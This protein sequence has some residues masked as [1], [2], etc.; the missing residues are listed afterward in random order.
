MKTKIVIAVLL[1]WLGLS[2]LT[3][4]GIKKEN[5]EASDLASYLD[6]YAASFSVQATGAQATFFSRVAV[7][8]DGELKDATIW[9]GDGTPSGKERKQSF[10]VIY[11]LLDNRIEVWINHNSSKRKRELELDNKYHPN[12]TS[13]TPR[14]NSDG[15]ISFAMRQTDNIS[16]GEDWTPSEGYVVIVMETREDR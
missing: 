9:H 16:T 8:V 5:L 11:K 12:V 13:P 10:T 4:A 15:S 6:L 14:T 7:Y 1:G 3:A 2:I